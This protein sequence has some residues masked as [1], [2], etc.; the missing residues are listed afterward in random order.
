MNPALCPFCNAALP[1]LAAAPTGDK[2][3]CPRCGESVPAA[4]W[5]VDTSIARGEPKWSPR[6][7]SDEPRPPVPGKRKTAL[8]ILGIMAT[9]AIVG[10]S[11]ALWTVDLRRS[12][13]PWMPTK[14]E[15]IARR[16]PLE[17]TGLGYLP[18]NCQFV[19]GLHI[20]EMMDDKTVGSKLLDEPRPVLLDWVLKQIPRATGLTLADIDHVVLG[21][22]FDRHFPQAVMVVKTRSP[23][24]LEKIARA[25]K[26]A[27][28]PLFHDKALYQYSLNPLG[29]AVV[30]CVDGRTLVYVLRLDEPKV[31]HL[32]GLSEE[33]RPIE[34]VLPAPLR[35]TL[36]ERL[37]THQYLWIAGRLDQL[38]P[39]KDWLPLALGGKLDLERLKEMKSF[40]LGIEPTEGLTLTG[41]FEMTDAKSADKLKTVLEGVTV[42]G[43][44]SQKVD[45]TDPIGHWVTWQVRGDVGTMREFLNQGREGK[46]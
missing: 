24:E 38:G 12:R 17:L 19:A 37:P 8:V 10:L 20:A 41:H 7:S 6:P 35:T 16:R 2:F 13:H 31:E 25:A 22:A 32:S 9:M 46:K 26:P 5:H 40:A 34:E 4:R 11:Y 33:P 15:P 21:A 23:Y 1:P 43:A 14:N 44:K 39:L 27:T 28:R 42:A 3:P 18:K 45:A 29:E 36:A 30:W